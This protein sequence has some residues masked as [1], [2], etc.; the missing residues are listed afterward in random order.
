ME[1]KVVNPWTWQDQ[2]GF[3]QAIEYTGAQRTVVC[4]GQASQSE[5]GTPIHE[6]DMQAQTAR[7]MDNLEGVLKQAGF[8]LADV[9]R[10]NIYTTDVDRFLAEGAEVWGR[11][12][13]ESGCR[14]TA[15]LLGIGRLAYPEL[16][17]E[18]EATAAA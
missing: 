6:G 10:L 12:L 14:P 9:I 3:V 8:R 18:F 15:T 2:F 11:R 13:A 17:V 4:S 7:A 5:D 1:R 16:M